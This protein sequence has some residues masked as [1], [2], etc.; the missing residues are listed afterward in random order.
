MSKEQPLR[1]SKALT[2]ENLQGNLSPQDRAWRAQSATVAM[3]K[4]AYNKLESF[5]RMV[6]DQEKQIRQLEDL[7][8]TD[9]LT[10]LMNR[11]GFEKFY[12]HELARIRRGNSPGA[13]FVI[14]DLDRF[15]PLNDCHGHQAGDACLK[16]IADNLVK[17]IR[18]VDGA[19]RLGGDEFAILLT[20]TEPERAM[21]RVH[22]L[23]RMLNDLRLDWNTAKLHI[24]ASFGVA[25]VTE[26]TEYASAYQAADKALYDEKKLRAQD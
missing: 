7:A 22:E 9:P 8:A 25:P 5:E 10:G 3:L 12:E 1:P 18:I 13:L 4:D 2:L 17:S 16:F 20:Q 26:T 24:G 14:I 19:A 6:A 11:R 21:V 23:R 15:K